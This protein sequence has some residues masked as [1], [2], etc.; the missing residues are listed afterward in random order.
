MVFKK[1]HLGMGCYRD[2]VKVEV[3]LALQLLEVADAAPVTLKLD[4]LISKRTDQ[5]GG[6]G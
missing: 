3:N 6:T 4:D 5:D 2:G 1:G